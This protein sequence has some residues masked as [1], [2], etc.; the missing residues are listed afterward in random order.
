MFPPVSQPPSLQAASLRSQGLHMSTCMF[1][2]L[3]YLLDGL[4]LFLADFLLLT[5][6]QPTRSPHPER[7]GGWLTKKA[8]AGGFSFSSGSVL[9]LKKITPYF[10]LEQ[11]L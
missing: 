1:I 3:F 7:G 11:W 9:K 10:K 4:S 8:M 6:C 5:G 2:V